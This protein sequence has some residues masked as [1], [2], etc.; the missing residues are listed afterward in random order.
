MDEERLA[1][2]RALHREG[3]A[4]KALAIYRELR[5]AEPARA[6]LSYLCSLAEQELGYVA[7]A[8]ESVDR[9]LALEPDHP[10]FRVH[11]GRLAQDAGDT[12]LAE[13]ELRRATELRP[14]WV[15]AWLD[16]G[17][18][19][20]DAQ[21]PAQ[22]LSCL[23]R[24]AGLDAKRARTWNSLGLALLELDRSAEA[25]EAFRKALAADPAYALAHLNLARLH[26]AGGDAGR[27][28]DHAREACRLAP[29]NA[30]AHVLAGDL[31]RKRR[32][33]PAALSAYRAAIAASPGNVRA[34]NALADLLWE[35]G[36]VDEARREFEAN[37]RDHPG[38]LKAALGSALLLPVVY[39]SRDHLS[40]CRERYRQGLEA[41]AGRA[42]DFAWKSEGEALSAI[43][44]T[45]FYLAYQ[46]GNDRELQSR[47]GDF[48]RR[49]LEPAAP[50]FLEPRPR[51]SRGGSRLRVGF[52]SF[53]FFNCTAGRYFA[54]WIRGLDASRF[55]AFVYYTNPWVADD[56]RAIAA[57]AA[58]FRHLPQ[59]PVHAVAG[60]ILED[61][62]DILVYPELGMHAD[63]F[64]LGSLRLAPVQCAGWGH[65][66]TTGLP[67]IDWFLSCGSME[68]EGAQA[69][70]RER[71]ALLPGLGTSYARPGGAST[72][73]RRDFGLPAGRRLYL[74]PQSLFK[75]HPDND[76]LIAEVLAR[77]PEGLAVLFEGSQPGLAEAFA[78]RIAPALASRGLST[79]RHLLFL[80]YMTHGQYLRVNALCDVMLDT[81]HWSGGNT[82]LDAIAMGL[83]I[84]TLPGELMRGRQSLGMLRALGLEELVA[85]DREDYARIATDLARDPARRRD[86]AARVA[87]RA[88]ELFDQQA[89]LKALAEFLES[90]A[91]A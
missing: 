1:Q 4:A 20:L 84:V 63:T 77:D 6:E 38:N 27:A 31:H 62:L 71:L 9:A 47:Y 57:S 48:I 87:A 82:S 36:A 51:R 25:G 43:R 10:H 85:R 61:D 16:L 56:T 32:D 73:E 21:R 17:T 58:H 14:G 78:S 91:A 46:G 24:A 35:T 53:F 29:R 69:A 66:T 19:L 90:A 68:P 26:D 64:A 76:E 11:S 39:A 75:I 37:H 83:P 80:P 12:A 23:E 2:A 89:P 50:R 34:R 8:R 88:G 65:P 60:Q 44:W 13:R 33:T 55:E 5:E 28:L 72:G 49:V 59:R 52:A 15:L 81:L 67:E 3:Q 40:R 22:A 54:S 41:L 70:Y 42:G 74:V 45:N 86:V 79:E 18:M 7:E 30:D